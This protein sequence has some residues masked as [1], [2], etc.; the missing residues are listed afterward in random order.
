[1]EQ[2]RKTSQQ[3]EQKFAEMMAKL[4]TPNPWDE[5]RQM[6]LE[7]ARDAASEVLRLAESMLRQPGD[8]ASCGQLLNY[9]KVVDFVLATLAASQDIKP[10]TLRVIFKLA[11]LP[12]DEAYP[13]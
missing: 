1:M 7:M 9:A 13:S 2:Q 11:G 6:E 12:V 3:D 8:L 10:A 5:K 4:L